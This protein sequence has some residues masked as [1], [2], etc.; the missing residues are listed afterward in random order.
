MPPAP[1]LIVEDEPQLRQL[2]AERLARDGLQIVVDVGAFDVVR[3]ALLIHISEQVLAGQ[4]LAFADN[5]C[6][7]RGLK[8]NLSVDARLADEPKLNRASP[9]F[10]VIVM[11]RRQPE[12]AVIFC[13][14]LVADADQRLFKERNDRRQHL[15]LRHARKS[16]VPLHPAL[17]AAVHR[18]DRC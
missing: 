13:V 9:D 18:R 7:A 5:R 1:I 11:D 17:V 2:L 15:L 16:Q 12:M 14:S 3:T 6:E 8:I 4:F 10:R